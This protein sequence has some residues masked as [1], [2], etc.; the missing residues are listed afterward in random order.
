MQIRRLHAIVGASA[1]ARDL[2]DALDAAGLISPTT[3][4]LSHRSKQRCSPTRPHC[5]GFRYNT[6]EWRAAIQPVLVRHG[7]DANDTLV[8]D[9][10]PMVEELNVVYAFHELVTL[11]T[12]TSIPG[13]TL[14]P[15]FLMRWLESGGQLDVPGEMLS[16]P[17]RPGTG[18]LSDP[19]RPIRDGDCK[20][21]GPNGPRAGSRKWQEPARL[22]DW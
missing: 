15:P 7:L 12:A 10:S 21:Y 16:E 11:S 6:D 9:E 2:Y 8:N 17:V 13:F 22:A 4:F 18:P 5:K 14:D 1:W 3:G 19:A 20:T